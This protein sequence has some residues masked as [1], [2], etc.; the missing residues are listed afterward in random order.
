M[1]T[2]VD[3]RPRDM[4]VSQRIGWYTGPRTSTG[5]REWL[6]YFVGPKRQQYA[7]LRVDGQSQRVTRLILGLKVGDPLVAMHR[8]DNSRCV[9]PAHLVA[10]TDADNTHDA[11]AK[12]RHPVQNLK[13]GAFLEGLRPGANRLPTNLCRKG[14]PRRLK[15]SGK[16]YCPTCHAERVREARHVD[17]R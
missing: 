16:L 2:Y 5:C 7:G 6:G 9:E 11:I 15:K 10:G 14:H 1:S 3:V 8:C 13:P 17:V 4:T 12:G